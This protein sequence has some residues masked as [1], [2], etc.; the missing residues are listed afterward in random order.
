MKIFS[1]PTIPT[2]FGGEIKLPDLETPPI[3]LPKMP[4]ERGKKVIGHGVGEDAAAII[5]LI[6]WIGDLVADAIIDCHHAEI[7]KILTDEEY[8]QFAEYNK[9][10]PTAPALARV[11]CF[12]KV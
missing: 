10:L 8:R 4:D 7:K 5:G 11:L 6:P 9:A 3:S 2:P 12:R 1:G